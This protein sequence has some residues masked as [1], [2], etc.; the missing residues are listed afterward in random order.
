VH[1][2]HQLLGDEDLAPLY[3][4]LID[5][6][7]LIRHAVGDLVYDHLIAQKFSSAQSSG[8]LQLRLYF[9][10][11]TLSDK[12][13][14]LSSFLIGSES[15]GSEVQ[16][17]RLLQILREFSSEPIL[18]DYVIDAVWQEMNAIKVVRRFCSFSALVI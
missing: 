3:D 8:I 16:L 10:L 17:S 1:Y 4:L 9:M 14:N 13:A 5:E 2:R 7:P 12:A 15:E 11:Y 6:S 18:S